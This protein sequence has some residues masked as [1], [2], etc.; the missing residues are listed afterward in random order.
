MT[1]R[2]RGLKATRDPGMLSAQSTESPHNK[3]LDDIQSAS[4]SHRTGA[5]LP[6]RYRSPREVSYS[7]SK[8]RTTLSTH[9]FSKRLKLQEDLDK[10]RERKYQREIARIEELKQREDLARQESIQRD[11]KRRERNKTLKLALAK[12]Q[13]DVRRGQR[14][15]QEESLRVEESLRTKERKRQQ[16]L[17]RQVRLPRRKR[18]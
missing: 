4:F 1:S 3:S 6:V 12:R 8:P 5:G 11:Q 7:F 15:K 9:S 10:Y 17:Q 14:E 13:E 16:Y 2:G 18:S